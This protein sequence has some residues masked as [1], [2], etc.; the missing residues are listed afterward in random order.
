MDNKIWS[1]TNEHYEEQGCDTFKRMRANAT[2]DEAIGFLRYNIDKYTHRKKSQ[3]KDDLIKIKAY[4]D[5]WL[6][7]I[8]NKG[9]VDE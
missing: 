9:E 1:N 4:A 3:D 8:D 2:Y 5:E 6:W 7:W